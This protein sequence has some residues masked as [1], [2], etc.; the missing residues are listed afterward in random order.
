[1]KLNIFYKGTKYQIIRTQDRHSIYEFTQE[2]G[3]VEK[4]TERLRMISD[5]VSIY[6]QNKFMK[7]QK[8]N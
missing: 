8:S 3:L 4:E 6:S 7:F 2:N 5:K 1:M